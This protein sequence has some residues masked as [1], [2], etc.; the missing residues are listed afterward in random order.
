MSGYV[1]GYDE[2]E[3]RRLARQARTLA[4]WTMDGVSFPA[5]ALVMEVG[6]GV[7]AE[8]VLLAERQPDLRLLG[9]DLAATQLRAAR[10]ELDAAGVRAPLVQ[11]SGA[12]LPVADARLD[13]IFTCWLM[14]HVPDPG[15]LAAECA[16]VLKPGGR[17]YAR[18]VDNGSFRMWPE[19]DDVL[20]Y[21]DTLNR[22]QIAYGGD[23][24]VSRRLFALL[25]EAGF[26]EVRMSLPSIY[27]DS[28]MPAPWLE[29][30]RY[31]HDLLVSVRGACVAAGL[32]E[33]VA[34]RALAH[35]KSLE[36][37][38]VGSIVHQPRFALA[39]R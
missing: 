38:R 4:P 26:A 16:R 36:T 6:C 27:A 10:R 39:I 31:F 8:L 29:L 28:S 5:G 7:G 21:M 12:R 14:E 11:A 30:V 18:E 32:P 22:V 1:H 35:V 17:F 9:C 25:V 15:A 3:V 24:F 19:S 34:D 20:R 33:D 23:P 2:V 13:G 37:S